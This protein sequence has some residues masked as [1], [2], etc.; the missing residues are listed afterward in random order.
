GIGNLARV[1]DIMT[2]ERYIDILCE[3]LEES[4]LKLDLETNFIF[5]QDND[6]KHKAKKTIAFFKSNKIKLL[7]WPPQSPDLNPIEN[8]WAYLDRN[9]DKTNVTDKTS[10]YAALQKAWEDIDPEYMKKLVE[11]MPRRLEAVLKTKGG[12]TKY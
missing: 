7:E 10:Y 12:N 6:P 3:N 5:Q 2:A 4:L 9:V 11:S 1:E 8:L